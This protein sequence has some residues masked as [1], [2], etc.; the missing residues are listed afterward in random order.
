[1]RKQGD[2]LT[3]STATLDKGGIDHSTSAFRVVDVDQKGDVQTMLRY[4]YINKSIETASIANDACTMTSDEKIPVSVNTYNA[5]APAI[6]VTYSC[7][8]D[9]NTPTGNTA[10]SKYRLELVRNGQTPGRL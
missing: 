9:G 4:T 10:Y 8:V 3:I 2:V 7:V 5:V 6:R 1:M